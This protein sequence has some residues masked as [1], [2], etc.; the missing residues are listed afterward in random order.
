[1]L[2]FMVANLWLTAVSLNPTE[3]QCSVFGSVF[4]TFERVCSVFQAIFMPFSVP[5]VDGFHR[6]KWVGMLRFRHRAND[7]RAKLDNTADTWIGACFFA[8]NIMKFLRGLLCLIFAKS[9]L[10]ALKSKIIGTID[11]LVE[12]LITTRVCAAKIN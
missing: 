10:E 1:M 6:L 8:K 3:R 4:G 11:D 5:K 2:R 7:I 12:V 9:G